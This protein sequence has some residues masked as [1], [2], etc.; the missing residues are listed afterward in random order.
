MKDIKNYMIE[1]GWPGIAGG[2]AYDL[3][4]SVWENMQPKEILDMIWSYYSSKD[5][6]N[7]LKWMRQDG[8]FE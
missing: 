7:L 5:L 1:E 4:L 3:I 6:E 8:Y 2:N